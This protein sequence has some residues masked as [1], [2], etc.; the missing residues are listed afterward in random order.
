[1]K[2]TL[3]TTLLAGLTTM[4]FAQTPTDQGVLTTTTTATTTT[5]TPGRIQTE[6]AKPRSPQ[7]APLVPTEGAIQEAVRTGRPL[8]MINPF[9]PVRYGSGHE[10]A[11]HDPQNPGKPK[12]IVLLS[13]SF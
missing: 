12:G 1:M 5:T 9:A 2:K 4:A 7:A 10:H 6:L 13:F 3:L 11:S 8:Q